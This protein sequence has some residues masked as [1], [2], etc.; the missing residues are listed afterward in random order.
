MALGL[1]IGWSGIEER[2]AAVCPNNISRIYVVHFVVVFG[3]QLT[4]EFIS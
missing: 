3:E 4:L 2:R 1:G